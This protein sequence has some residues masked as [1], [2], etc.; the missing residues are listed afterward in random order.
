MKEIIKQT[1]MEVLEQTGAELLVPELKDDVVLLESGLD[2]LGFAILV[3]T[4]EEKLEFDPFTMMDEPLYPSTFGEFV[5]I[6]EKMNP[7]K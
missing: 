7:N 3:A 4:L 5:S 1:Y 2:S 6:Y